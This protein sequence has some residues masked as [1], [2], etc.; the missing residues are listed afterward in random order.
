MADRKKV[1]RFLPII[2]TW[3]SYYQD[4]REGM[5]TVYERFI[6]HEIFAALPSVE[7]IESI[8]EVPSFGMTGISGINSLWW[9]RNNRNVTV[10][11]WNHNRLRLI[12]KT[13]HSLQLPVHTIYWKDPQDLPFADHSFDLSWNFASLWFMNDLQPFVEDLKRISRRTILICVPNISGLGLKLRKK[14]IGEIDAIK[15]ENIEPNLVKKSFSGDGW[16]LYNEGIFD[17]P[18][19][20]DIPVKKEVI[21]KKLKLSF[22]LNRPAKRTDN[23]KENRSEIL[24]YFSGADTELRGS[25]MKYSIFENTF[26]FIKKYWG[27]HRFFIFTRENE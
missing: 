10:L 4:P 2:D 8:L 9:G 3:E 5:G 11:D 27:H 1:N 16:K 15:L 26:N 17:V 23:S 14:Y 13:W 18:P 21:L 7:K 12:R 6:L 25:L 19:W 24:D 22:L 20:P